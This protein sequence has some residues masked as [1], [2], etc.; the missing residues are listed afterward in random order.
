MNLRQTS[1]SEFAVAPRNDK[2]RLIFHALRTEEHICWICADH[3]VKGYSPWFA[4][5]IGDVRCET[6]FKCERVHYHDGDVC[7]ARRPRYRK[8]SRPNGPDWMPHQLRKGHFQAQGLWWSSPSTTLSTGRSAMFYNT[9]FRGAYVHG[10]RFGIDEIDRMGVFGRLFWHKLLVGD[11]HHF[12]RSLT[13]RIVDIHTDTD[14]FVS[15]I[16]DIV[17]FYIQYVSARSSTERSVAMLAYVKKRGIALST[18]IKISIA[19]DHGFELL[20][21][22]LGKRVPGYSGHVQCERCDVP[23]NMQGGFLD[24][25]QECSN[26]YR[27]VRRSPVFKKVEKFFHFLVF[28]GVL[29][30]LGFTM[31]AME[32][33]EFDVR[34]FK[35]EFKIGPDLVHSFVDSTIFFCQ[36]GAQYAMTGTWDILAHTSDSYE[37][38]L[39]RARDIRRLSNHTSNLESQGLSL[40]QYIHDL[41]IAIDQGES[42]RKF[43]ALDGKEKMFFGS[44]LD[45]LKSIDAELLTR[46]A[47]HAEREA[48]FT[49]LMSGASAVGKS[50]LQRLV[51]NHLGHVLS[52]PTTDEYIYFR[53]AG[54]EYWDNFN[55]SMWCIVIDDAA[56]QNP[57]YE[58]DPTVK[59]CI[60]LRNNVPFIPNQAD[61]KDKG[62]TPVMAKA[63]LISTNTKHLNANAYFSHPMA[64]QRRFPYILSVKVKPEYADEHGRIRESSIPQPTNESY[65]DIW[66]IVVEKIVGSG[67]VGNYEAVRNFDNIHDFLHWMTGVVRE[68]FS[69]QKKAMDT[70]EMMKGTDVCEKCFLPP[71]HCHCFVA[72]G[73]PLDLLCDQ[74]C[75]QCVLQEDHF[76]NFRGRGVVFQRHHE[77]YVPLNSDKQVI[78][79]ESAWSQIKFWWFGFICS[80]VILRFV[81]EIT[82]GEHWR[83]RLMVRLFQPWQLLRISLKC[84]GHRA[85]RH[86]GFAKA[87]LVMMAAVASLSVLIPFLKKTF[88]GYSDLVDAQIS[89]DDEPEVASQPEDTRVEAQGLAASIGEAPKEQI[90]TEK[91]NVWY[92]SDPYVVSDIDVSQQSRTA[93]S[94]PGS[95]DKLAEKVHANV[96]R[97]FITDQ[98]P[99]V[100]RRKFKANTAFNVAGH[101]WVMNKHSCFQP[102]FYLTMNRTANTKGIK[103][104]AKDVYVDES[105]VLFHPDLD[106]AFVNLLQFPPGYSLRNYFG[107]ECLNGIYKGAYYGLSMSGVREIKAVANLVRKDPPHYCYYDE[108]ELCINGHVWYGRVDEDTIQGSCGTP[109]LT[110]HG[111]ILG[112]HV[113]GGSRNTIGA[114]KVSRELVE[115]ALRHFHD[116][117]FERGP[118]PYSEQGAERVLGPVHEKSPVMFTE[119]GYANVYG[120]FRDFRVKH[121]SSVVPTLLN[122]FLSQKGYEEKYGPPDMGYMPEWI[123]L[124]DIVNTNMQIPLAELRECTDA[125]IQDA[126]EALPDGALTAMKVF[127]L[128]TAVNG[129]AGVEY[130]DKLKRNTSAGAP[131]KKSKRHFLHPVEGPEGADWVALDPVIESRVDRIIEAYQNKKMFHPQFCAQ[132]KD[133]PRKKRRIVT[134]ETRIFT[135]A[136]MAWTVV[137]RMYLLS[138]VM[139]VQTHRH[140]FEAY[141]GTVAQSLEWEE[142]FHRLTQHGHLYLDGDYKTFDSTMSAIVMMEAMRVIWTFAK[143]AGYSDLE[144]QV[145]WGIA[146]DTSFSTVDYFGCLI[147]LL[148]MNPS[149]HALTVVI[150]CIANS[151]YMR[152][153]W[154]RLSPGPEFPLTSFRKYVALATYGDDNGL[155]VSYETM[156]FNHTAIQ[157]ALKEIG[158]IYTMANKEEESRPFGI[159]T[160][161]SFLKRSW[162]FDCDIGA[163]VGPLELESIEKMLMTTMRSKTICD[164][165]RDIA[166]VGSAV[167]EYFFHGRVIFEEK[168]TLLKEAVVVSGLSMY[169]EESTFPSFGELVRTFWMN[170]KHMDIERVCSMRRFGPLTELGDLVAQGCKISMSG[171][172]LNTQLE[173]TRENTFSSDLIRPTILQMIANTLRGLCCCGT[174]QSCPSILESEEGTGSLCPSLWERISEEERQAL[175][176]FL[177]MLESDQMHELRVQGD[178]LIEET[179]GTMVQQENVHF[180][181]QN[182]GE[183]EGIDVPYDGVSGNDRSI[184]SDLDEFFR[185]PVPL[186]NFTWLESDAVGTFRT[187]YPWLLWANNTKIKK[188]L[189]NFAFFRGKLHLKVLINASPFY[190][191]QMLGAYYPNIGLTP[192]LIV[193]DGANRH[194]ILYSQRPHIWLEAQHSKGDEIILP[195]FYHKNWLNIQSS[196]DVGNF[197]RMDFVNY[198]QLQSANGVTGQGVTVQVYAWMEDVELSGPSAGLAVQG[199]ESDE[200][201]T[202]VVSAPATAI[203]NAASWFENIPVIGR[204]AT[205]TRMGASAVSAIASLFGFTNV[206]VIE[207]CRPFRSEPVGQLA[208]TSIGYPAQKLVLDP[209]NELTI[210]PGTLGL[211]PAD[212][213]VI[214]N[215]VQKESWLCNTTWTTANSVDDILFSCRAN[216]TLHDSSTVANYAVYLTPM[217]WIAQLFRDWRGDVIFRFKVVASPYHK[218]RLRISYDPAGNAATN[219]IIADASTQMVVQTQILDLGGE[220][221]VEIRLPYQQ[222]TAWLQT[223][224][225]LQNGAV[226]WSTSLTPGFPYSA[227]NDNGTITMRVQTILTAPVATSSV[228]IM[229]FVRGAENLEFANP[230][231]LSSRYSTFA[232]QG[233]EVY[234]DPFEI[235]AGKK[236]EAHPMRHVVNFGE[237]IKSLRTLLRRSTLCY[238]I[239][240]TLFGSNKVGYWRMRFSKYPPMP[241]Y[242]NQSPFTA[243]GIVNTGATFPYNWNFMSPYNWVAPAFAAQR[244]S[245]IWTFAIEANGSSGM[246]DLFRVYRDTSNSGVAS[247]QTQ[248]NS[249]VSTQNQYAGWAVTYLQGG[250]AGQALAVARTNAGLQVSLPNY[251][252]FRYMSTIPTYSTGL[253]SVDDQDV[254]AYAFEFYSSAAQLFNGTH[255]QAYQGIGTDF[256]LYFFLNVPTFYFYGTQPVAN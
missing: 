163:W 138:F 182:P 24:D 42:I 1:K 232:A 52:L 164:E 30:K 188:K 120:S 156:W 7:W 67:R 12:L 219:N 132:K 92:Y 248:Q 29:D 142:L 148:G 80:S 220:D 137:V 116:Y 59:E 223:R 184:Q 161:G 153:A 168:V 251:T 91:K 176:A 236:S 65:P 99:S 189:D 93:A 20:Y 9:P 197:G 83:W 198:T 209:K 72:Q 181:D 145:V 240:P 253:T 130:C 79:D 196:S 40:H 106:L 245:M 57:N 96:A 200:Y 8:R 115:G 222:A 140:A 123:K 26:F 119:S 210:D 238:D 27:K 179:T 110:S 55:S 95:F 191:G 136:E 61:L 149:G 128:H 19:M 159:I 143:L 117:G 22:K 158:I 66:L 121:K 76:C 252:R 243:T 134:K 31:A 178:V 141:P 216:P 125:Y 10:T 89:N 186:T 185:R 88:D 14:F 70:A 256:G 146:L 228:T 98:H 235:T 160:K 75:T 135:G 56:F 11:T 73:T 81:C 78:R 224:L 206:P 212:D 152:F 180:L 54:S 246:L 87:T 172:T 170:S 103:S 192:D 211:P 23:L 97:I 5:A 218:G 250:S 47:A 84:A 39:D 107:G 171:A 221:D 38:W 114:I 183:T 33:D 85:E 4:G 105:M 201:G 118:I 174:A 214:S 109:L 49:L 202:G 60:Q 102:P 6:L 190:Y 173:G 50:M 193:P 112:I 215:L 166:I 113:L 37:S 233:A 90:G 157:A 203:A 71:A 237:D 32:F 3:M 17:M 100:E 77:T 247:I 101:V 139:L 36:I 144:L 155:N 43:G 225:S 234:G 229:V 195:F 41:K 213:M 46:K 241:G 162:R 187:I 175:Y 165:A 45:S 205:A 63:V 199:G 86:I 82:L 231:N 34:N 35:R 194:L 147:Q 249:V 150:N 68:H 167:R 255:V 239:R 53:Q 151:I 25:A 2:K 111:V 44:M 64:V 104:G 127:D 21:K 254:D 74:F 131:F 154:K 169:V 126:L 124:Q 204:F 108:V 129:Q 13:G 230:I 208:T 244:G 133:E 207:D 62:R 226:G 15:L 48:P 69:N 16:E 242:D 227:V 58:I 94:Q 18:I 217:A 122:D 177:D 51:I 28:K